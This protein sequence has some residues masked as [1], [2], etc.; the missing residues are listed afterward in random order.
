MNNTGVWGAN[1]YRFGLETVKATKTFTHP[2]LRGGV[3]NAW[4]TP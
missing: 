4:K 3:I 1:P 2:K